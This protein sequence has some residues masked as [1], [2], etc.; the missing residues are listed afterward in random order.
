MTDTHLMAAWQPKPD[1]TLRVEAVDESLPGENE[2][3]VHNA[4]LAINPA[5]W[6]L[7]AQPVGDW[8]QYPMILGN[9]VAGEVVAIGPGVTRFAVGDRVLGQ[10]VGCWTNTPAKGGFQTRTILDVNLASPMPNSMT[11]TQ[12]CVL[13]LGIGTAACGLFQTDHLGLDHPRM[14][15]KKSGI[16]VLVWGGASSVGSCAIQ[17]A[18][19]AGYDVVTTASPKNADALKALGAR[20]VIDYHRNDVVDAVVAA[21]DGHQ[22]AG[23]IFTVGETG[24][25]YDAVSRLKGNRTVASTL[26]IPEDKPETV[27]AT[28]I[29]GLTLRDNEMGKAIYEDYLPEALKNG[30]LKPAPAARIVGNGLDALQAAL[31]T[32]KAGVSAEK[33]VV[34]LR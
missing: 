20:E 19:A 3:A 10:A 12:A 5:D 24:P 16:T 17:L 7:Q 22:I 28:Q 30:S 31:E 6:I 32:Q 29:F 33:I 1:A 11:Y 34:T 26:P 27:T 15:A 14:G 25:C 8:M 9:D 4:A 13:P 18:V 21:F 2:I 23:A